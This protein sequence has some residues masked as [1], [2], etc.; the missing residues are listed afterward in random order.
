M[1][2]ETIPS[3]LAGERLDRGV[4]LIAGCSRSEAAEL[5]ACGGV[6]L[7]GAPALLGK[8]RLVEGQVVSVDESRV[9]GEALPEP[10]PD[11]QFDIVHTDDDVVVIDKP[12]GLVVH[13]AAGHGGGTLVN[14]ILARFPE[15]AGV[16]ERHRPGIVH[17]LDVGTSGLLVVARTQ[18]AYLALVDALA[19]RSVGRTYLALA[20]GHFDNANGVIDAPVGRDRR[21]PQRMAV[22]VDGKPSRTRYAVL[23]E[24]REPAVASLLECRLESGRTHQIRV[25]LAAIEHPVAGD[26]TY[27]GYRVAVDVPRPFL[28]AVTL[29]FDHPLSGRRLRFDSPLPSDLA[30]VLERFG[31]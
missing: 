1:I 14:G 26:A 23:R 20:W 7:D 27:G 28:H 3:A 31:E 19:R 22:V 13:P 17:R 9:P 4:S 16:G 24:F 15:I 30:D 5:L 2:T 12:A 29:E 11:V 10:D 6:T 18:R 8:Q 25:H 21:D